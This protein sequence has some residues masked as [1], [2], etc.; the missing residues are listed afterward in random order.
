MLMQFEGVVNC[1]KHSMVVKCVTQ[2]FSSGDVTLQYVTSCD[3]LLYNHVLMT[4][5]LLSRIVMNVDV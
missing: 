1:L 5:C 3:I 2:K 4:S